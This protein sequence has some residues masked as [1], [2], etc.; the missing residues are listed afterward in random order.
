MTTEGRGQKPET[1]SKV[2]VQKVQYG[3]TQTKRAITNVLNEVISNYKY[4]SLPELNAVLKVYNVMADRGKEDTEM[5]QKRGLVYTALD[6]NGNKIGTPIKAS[7]LYNKPTLKYLEQ[8]FVQNETLRQAHQRKLRVDIHMVLLREKQTLPHFTK[9]LAAKGVDV[10]IRQNDK[11]VIYG[12]TYID[13]TSKCVFNGSN[14]GKEFS[15][16]GILEQLGQQQRPEELKPN[17]MEPNQVRQENT[18][19]H[20]KEVKQDQEKEIRQ[21]K[22]NIRIASKTRTGK[23]LCS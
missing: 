11:G 13:F 18:R 16:K 12:I 4:T 7:A 22:D 9:A 2:R 5:F 17:Q 15:A 10:I 8:K 20:Q 1:G 23:Q 21:E 6:D 19:T 14:L 3:K